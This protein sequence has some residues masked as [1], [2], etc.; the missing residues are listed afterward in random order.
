MACKQSVQMKQGDG[1]TSYAHNSTI[2]SKQQNKMKPLIEE[3]IKSLFGAMDLLPGRMVIADLGCAFGPNSLALVSTA[4][5]AV[6]HH[7]KMIEQQPLDICV[8][9]NDLPDNDFNTVAESLST[10]KQSYEALEQI[11]ITTGMV[12]GSFYKRLFPRGSLHLICS[13][14]S[15]HWLSEAPEDIV[16]NRIPLY[17]SNNNLSKESSGVILDAYG[18]QFRKDFTQFLRLR[19]QELVPGGHMILSLYGRRSENQSTHGWQHIVSVLN[20]MA[21]R[22]VIDKQKFDSFYIP[23]YAPLEKELK[24]IIEAEGSFEI[25]KAL[26]HEPIGPTLVPI[27]RALTIRAV[28]E[29]IILK[30]FG[31]SEAIMDEFIRTT[32]RHIN[33]RRLEGARIPLVFLTVSL[34]NLF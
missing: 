19:A 18:Q 20:D 22:G 31:A 6:S 17:D 29:P 3:A 2:Q 5:D 21:S 9:L 27:E 11:V 12:P 33:Y 16:R 1:E 8:L 10:F 30:H 25:N 14:T 34:R 4:V 28:F 26:V 15:L 32:E 23:M 24:T 7:I 13:S